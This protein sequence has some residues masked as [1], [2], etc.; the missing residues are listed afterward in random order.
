MI[1]IHCTEQLSLC[2]RAFYT[3]ARVWVCIITA[4]TAGER[5]PE[6]I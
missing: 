4:S 5:L 3:A 2:G 6:Q 1:D